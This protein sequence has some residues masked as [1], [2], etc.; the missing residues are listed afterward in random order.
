MK[1]LAELG[2]LVERDGRN[3]RSGPQ[4][5]ACFST[6]FSEPASTLRVFEVDDPATRRR[7]F[8][9]RLARPCGAM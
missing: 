1:S 7:S 5:V 9:R 3:T 4:P 8:L 6:S 2:A